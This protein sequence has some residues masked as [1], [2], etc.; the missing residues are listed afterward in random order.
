[1]KSATEL[2]TPAGKRDGLKNTRRALRRR[3][4]RDNLWGY[5]FLSPW[6]IGFFLLTLGPMLVS[7]YLAMT[8]FDLFTAPEWVGLGNFV[9]MF[10]DDPKFMNSLRV[11]FTFVALGVPLELA[12]ALIVALA[13]NRG[14]R[15]LGFYRS[16]Y[17]VPSLLGGSVAIAVLWRQ[18]FG[19]EG[20]MNQF[21]ALFGIQGPS[22]I[23]DPSYSIYTLI[24]LNIWQFGAPMVIFLAGLRQ[25]PSDLYDSAAVDGASRMRIFFRI[26][27]PLLSP[28]IFFN[29]VLRIVQAFQ[30]FAPAYIISNGSGG[31]LDSTLFYTL[32]IYQEGFVNFRMGYASALAW[33]LLVTIMAITAINFAL[34][35]YWVYY[36]N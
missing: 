7:L 34:S 31:P 12:F 18:V 13:L 14:L 10:T 6:L 19:G 16:V 32:Y 22:W 4:R 29:L 8:D 33:F 5:V 36:E 1:M 28:V 25:I 24:V 15:G 26:T 21:L 2:D 23:S 17:Y 35:K 11:T 27:I 20:L 9:Q 3:R 30:A